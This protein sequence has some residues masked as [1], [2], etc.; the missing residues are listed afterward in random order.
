[1]EEGRGEIIRELRAINGQLA[2]QNSFWRLFVVG[3]IYG[4]G[5]FFGSAII[6][7]IAFGIIGPWFAEVPWVRSAFETGGAMLHH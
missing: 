5:F 7:T 6:A 2:K 4:L 1:M 3:I